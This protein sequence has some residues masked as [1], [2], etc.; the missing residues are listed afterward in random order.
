MEAVM[1]DFEVYLVRYSPWRLIGAFETLAQAV[2]H[3][4]ASE[5]E[6]TVKRD[7]EVV[8]A[9]RQGPRLIWTELV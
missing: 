8:G 4:M 3:G 7:G 6:F 2:A 9:A 1:S 5:M